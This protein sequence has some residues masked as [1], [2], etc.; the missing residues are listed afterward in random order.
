MGRRDAASLSYT[1]DAGSSRRTETTMTTAT[2][3][4][5]TIDLQDNSLSG[6]R[7]WFAAQG[8]TRPRKG[9]FLAGV[10]AGF[11]RRYGVHPLVARLLALT[12]M[13][14]LT[15][16]VYVAA[17]ILMPKDAPDATPAA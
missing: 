17:W 9:R 13:L 5:S 6:A 3:A 7:A 8:L 16:L 10:T 14:V 15:P 11:A 2:A 12:T 4:P 1:N